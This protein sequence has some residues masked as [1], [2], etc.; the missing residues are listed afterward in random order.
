[1]SLQ[2]E[3]FGSFVAAFDTAKRGD[4]ILQRVITIGSLAGVPVT[5]RAFRR[6]HLRDVDIVGGREL[7]GI[8]AIRNFVV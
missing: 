1:M 2:Q 6:L 4:L 5:G 3:G 7:Q 8:L